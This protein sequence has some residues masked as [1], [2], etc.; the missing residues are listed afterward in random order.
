MTRRI[1]GITISCMKDPGTHI[2]FKENLSKK[3][4]VCISI[5]QEEGI[6]TLDVDSEEEDEEEV[7]VKVEVRLFSII[8]HSQEI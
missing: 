3:E 1:V 7:W 8:V 5:P 6:S 4:T 2:E